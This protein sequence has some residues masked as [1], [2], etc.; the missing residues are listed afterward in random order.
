MKTS[1]LCKTTTVQ[2]LAMDGQEYK[3][4]AF[5]H[6]GRGFTF[7]HRP[8]TSLIAIPFLAMN[9]PPGNDFYLCFVPK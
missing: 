6:E 4:T 7:S 3:L 9:L 2:Q 5:E 1:T 8:S